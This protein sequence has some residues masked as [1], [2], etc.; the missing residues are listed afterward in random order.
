[1]TSICN[2]FKYIFKRIYI[3]MK[4]KCIYIFKYFCCNNIMSSDDDSDVIPN[5]FDTFFNINNLPTPPSTPLH[6][7]YDKLEVSLHNISDKSEAPLEILTI[8]EIL[9]NLKPYDKLFI[10]DGM[11]TVDSSYI[12]YIS[13]WWYNQSAMKTILYIENFVAENL[14]YISNKHN[15]IQGLINLK[16]TYIDR[17]DIC[18]KLEEIIKNI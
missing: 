11:L 8:I 1:M 4:H 14:K 17:K 10:N 2:A 18:D 15:F 16:K 6:D 13:R 3:S 7:R 5:N 9:S 12:P